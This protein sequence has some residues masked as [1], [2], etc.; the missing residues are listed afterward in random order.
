MAHE[1]YGAKCHI[2]AHIDHRGRNREPVPWLTMKGLACPECDFCQRDA[3]HRVLAE[4]GLGLF[5]AETRKAVHAFERGE[6]HP[7][8][9][10]LR[11]QCQALD[12]TV[13]FMGKRWRVVDA[14]HDQADDM[15]DSHHWHLT[16]VEASS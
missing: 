14:Q 2:C 13:E 5:D 12:Q 1:T 4:G 7:L 8:I 10:K 15:D 9:D 16:L 3:L 11:E 6:D